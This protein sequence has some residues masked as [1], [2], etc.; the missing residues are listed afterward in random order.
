MLFLGDFAGFHRA[1]PEWC[2][3]AGGQHLPHLPLMGLRLA[4]FLLNNLLETLPYSIWLRLPNDIHTLNAKFQ[5]NITNGLNINRKLVSSST[6]Y[7]YLLNNKYIPFIDCIL[8]YIGRYFKS[9]YDLILIGY[10]KI[11]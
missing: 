7:T 1:Y 11:W 5:L 9:I 8:T 10:I 4:P 3:E 2:S 6:R